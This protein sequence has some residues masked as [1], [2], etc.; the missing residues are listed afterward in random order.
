V[1]SRSEA[2]RAFA[3][4]G[5]YLN[6]ERVDDPDYVPLPTDYLGGR[7]LVLRRGKKSFAGVTAP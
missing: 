5:A 2:R 4:G 3:E 1:S 7:V 6:N